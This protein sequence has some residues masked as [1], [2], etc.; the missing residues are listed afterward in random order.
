MKSWQAFVPAGKRHLIYNATTLDAETHEDASRQATRA[1]LDIA[2][3]EQMAISVGT[4]CERKSQVD[5]ARA[6]AA[7]PGRIRPVFVGKA[8][9]GYRKKV[10]AALGE[11]L[12]RAIFTGPVPDAAGMI[13][14]AD[15]LV[16]SSR[17]EAFPRTLLEA[18]ALGTP[19]IATSLAGT[20]ERLAHEESALLYPPGDVA[21]LSRLLEHLA[22]DRTLGAR[23]AA[24]AQ[25][26]LT[27]AWTHQDMIAAYADMVRKALG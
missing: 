2:P 6:A 23:L 3:D 17:S 8:E 13:A 22:A 24:T 19:I 9:A 12:P 7:A 21:S 11:A 25:A 15:V 10:E 4:L 16:C 27:Q 14:A 26:R 20:M 1:R 18:A 5:F